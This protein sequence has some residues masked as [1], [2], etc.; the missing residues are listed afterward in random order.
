MDNSLAENEQVNIKELLFPYVKNWKYYGL[1]VLIFTVL[2]FV[3]LKFQVNK[4]N[5][6][7]S[8]LVKDEQKN[9]VQDQLSDFSNLGFDLGGVK[10]KLENEIE[11]LKNKH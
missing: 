3:Y 1:S 8:I 9:Q 2:S 11:I 6:T 4:Y 10:S 7:A 5:V